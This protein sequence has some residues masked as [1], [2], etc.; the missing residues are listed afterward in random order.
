M[1]TSTSNFGKDNKSRPLQFFFEIEN[2]DLEMLLKCVI[3][4]PDKPQKENNT[5]WY[6]LSSFDLPEY[7]DNQPEI[8]PLDFS[9]DT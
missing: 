1:V 3:H 7:I 6:L 4:I 5:I 2:R 9:L 8:V